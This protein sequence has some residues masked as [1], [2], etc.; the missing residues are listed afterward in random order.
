MIKNQLKD[1]WNLEQVLKDL[2]LFVQ[3]KRETKTFLLLLP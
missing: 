3:S 2:A 1:L